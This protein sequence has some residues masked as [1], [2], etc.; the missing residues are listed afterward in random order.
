MADFNPI[1]AGNKRAATVDE[2]LLNFE[3]LISGKGELLTDGIIKGFVDKLEAKNGVILSSAQNMKKIA[4]LDQAYLTF[5]QS[6]A[7]EIVST[8]LTDMDKI[9]SLNDNYFSELMGGV[10]IKAD[11]VKRV[12]RERLGVT[13]SGELIREGY[14]MGLLQDTTV[15]NEI[16]QYAYEKMVGG[17]GFQDMRK[18]M[19][20]LIQGEGDKLGVFNRFY[21]NYAF[22]SYAQVDATNG[23]LMADK[24]G[25]KYFIYNGGI[26]RD[27]K[28]KSRSRP[29]CIK[30][31]GK[32]FSSQEADK[33]KNDPDLTAI[34]SR[35]SYNWQIQRGGYACRHSID[36][37]SEEL[38]F[39]LRPELE[40]MAQP[41]VA[42]DFKNMGEVDE[43]M[44]SR[45]INYSFD[46][47]IPDAEKLSFANSFKD[48][49]KKFSDKLGVKFGDTV[50]VEGSTSKVPFGKNLRVSAKDYPG[51]DVVG[52]YIRTK[53]YDKG[54][55][56]DTLYF[57]LGQIKK[58]VDFKDNIAEIKAG[59]IPAYNLTNMEDIIAHEAGHN[60][61]FTRSLK[62]RE[63]IRD[64]YASGDNWKLA[65]SVYG[66]EN[67]SEMYA[68]AMA[69]YLRG[70]RSEVID[71][72]FGNTPSLA[73]GVS[74]RGAFDTP[75]D[76]IP[77]L[78]MLDADKAIPSL[79]KRAAEMEKIDAAMVAADTEVKGYW[80]KISQAIKGGIP[81]EYD[82]I[83]AE[84]S[85]MIKELKA[86]KDKREQISAE[87]REEVIKSMG[88][89]RKPS[90]I[91]INNPYLKKDGTPRKGAEVNVATF[92]KGE[93]FY[94]RFIGQGVNDH[95]AELTYNIAG[96]RAFYRDYDKI[97]QLTNGGSPSTVV[98]ELAHNTEYAHNWIIKRSVDFH[99]RR[100]AGDKVKRLK[101]IFPTHG[102]K[103]DEITMEDKFFTPYVGK[104]YSGSRYGGRRSTE[105]ISMGIERIFEDPILFFK[106]DPDHFNFIY[107]LFSE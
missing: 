37:I 43:W 91:K 9:M 55:D 16:R 94:R 52:E 89:N 42:G 85:A 79:K 90:T 4:L 11:D 74:T 97:V 30:R 50:A 38:A 32:V 87:V 102:Y 70:D 86:L 19:R 40:Q 26:M 92:Q 14:M 81:G 101:D 21:R 59:R 73:K 53:D 35:D 100:T 5:Q 15:R 36:Y 103:A 107:S 39:S 48:V 61:Y 88:S 71:R 13:A 12:I 69:G 31:A 24:L 64:F 51:S 33:W 66:Q 27:S 99:E 95:Y 49:D 34:E 56:G 84:R 25:L 67:A 17:T 46:D 18:G 3:A 1:R 80:S 6:H 41:E 83:I 23:K 54:I 93:D 82:K 44:K 47:D 62:E 104:I 58:N 65:N 22:D 60:Y 96:N 106:E 63:L 98:H 2:L 75:F 77:E 20:D 76:Q 68:E 45:G 72:F 7:T 29:F 57:N 78:K 105:I 28:G 10:Q 8:L